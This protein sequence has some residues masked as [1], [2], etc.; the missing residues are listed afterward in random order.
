MPNKLFTLAIILASYFLLYLVCLLYNSNYPFEYTI[1]V[2]LLVGAIFAAI[3]LVKINITDV[4]F[5]EYASD[6]NV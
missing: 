1:A 6:N 3:E 5:Q 4:N 2:L